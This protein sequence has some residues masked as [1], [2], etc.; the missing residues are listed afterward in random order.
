MAVQLLQSV[1]RSGFVVPLVVAACAPPVLAAE[2]AANYP[3]KPV[4]IIIANTTG[5]S[6]DTLARVLAVKMGD[7][8]GQQM[9]ADNRGGAGGIIGAEITAN[10]APDGYTLLVSS[11]GMQ[12]ITPQLYKKL[13]YEPIR[14]FAMISMFAVTQNMMVT[15]PGV[16]AA[17]VKELLAYARANPGRLN[18][19]N[20]GTGFQSH[21]AGVLFTHMTGID[22]RHVPYKGGASLIAVMG[23]ESQFTIAPAPA[24][25]AH[26][27][28]GRLK[29]LG[30]GGEKRSPLTPD[31]PA[32]NE[33]VPGYVS[34]GWSGLM[35][36][37]GTPKSILDKLHATLAKALADGPTKEALERQGGEP[38]LTS[39]Q[40]MQGYIEADYKRFAQAIKIANLQPQ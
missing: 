10:A 6:V 12:V 40:E 29:A 30:T 21:L 3:T 27:R 2:A 34:T 33:T 25:M 35:A 4:R 14:S 37:R 19:S 28:G 18:M 24:V 26:V 16:P 7:M 31:L 32:I 1:V 15:H 13:A 39:P 11:T 8:L 36:P 5:T 17:N 22:V 9:V 38:W 20:A 23:N